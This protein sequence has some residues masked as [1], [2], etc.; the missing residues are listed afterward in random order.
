MGITNAST[1]FATFGILGFFEFTVL[2]GKFGLNLHGS[3]RVMQA[4]NELSQ[5]LIK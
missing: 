2:S 1:R 5:W 4:L 3:K